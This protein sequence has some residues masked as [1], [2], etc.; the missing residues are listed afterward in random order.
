LAGLLLAFVV[1]QAIPY[2]RDHSNP[3]QQQEPAWDSQQTR[4]LVV[5]ACFDCHSNRTSW[6]WYSNIAPLS[7][8][9]QHDVDDG[10]ETLNFSEWDRPQPEAGE[11]AEAVQ[12]GEM[13]PRQYRLLHSAGRLS[14]AE[15][16]ALVQG[17]EAT[18]G[19]EGAKGEEHEEEE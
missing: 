16:Q 8:L 5:D 9:I 15:R 11:A 18:F 19:R 17:L 6:A 2:G 7:W 4:A 1:I 10:R 3:S 12:E 14:S 13:P